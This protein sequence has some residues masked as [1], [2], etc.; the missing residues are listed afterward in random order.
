MKEK[1]WYYTFTRVTI[2]V[3]TFLADTVVTSDSVY[4]CGMPVTHVFINRTLVQFGAVELVDSIVTRKTLT[5]IRADSVEALGVRITMMTVWSTLLLAL[6]YIWMTLQERNVIDRTNNTGYLYFF[7]RSFYRLPIWK[8]V[9]IRLIRDLERRHEVIPKFSIDEKIRI[10]LNKKEKK[11]Q[12]ILSTP[13][14]C[15]YTEQASPVVNLCIINCTNK[16]SKP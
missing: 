3:V 12:E 16:L 14:R 13:M 4:A 9:Q 15:D 2:A 11:T 10:I 8:F 6:V 5:R 7:R 1:K